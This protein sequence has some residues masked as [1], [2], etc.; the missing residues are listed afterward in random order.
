MPLEYIIQWLC[1]LIVLILAWYIS[2]KIARKKTKNN[3]LK[4]LDFYAINS[5]QSIEVFQIGQ[6]EYIVF[7]QST[8]GINILKQGRLKELKEIPVEEFLD[9]KQ[10]NKS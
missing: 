7:S 10:N 3:Y 4:R 5:G 6:N 2:H 1:L 9:S 8:H